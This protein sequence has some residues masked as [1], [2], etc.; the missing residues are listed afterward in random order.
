[1][2]DIVI[3]GGGVTGGAIARKLSE[4]KLK[5]A[6]LEK[7]DDVCSGASKAN[8]GRGVISPQASRGVG[9][10]CRPMGL[11]MIRVLGSGM[12]GACPSA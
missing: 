8:S 6:V 4:Y 3:I 9:R 7:E 10:A 5:V 11:P 1:M 2:Y 12:A